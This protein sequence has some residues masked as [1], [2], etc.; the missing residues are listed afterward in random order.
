MDGEGE[1]GAGGGEAKDPGPDT[2]RL[3]DKPSQ[4]E[5]LV[6]ARAREIADRLSLPRPRTDRALHRSGR[7]QRS[8]PYRDGGDELDLDRSIEVLAANPAPAD[9]DLFIR[10]RVR[11]PRSVVLLVDV[12]GSM[13]GERIHT[14]AATVGALSA[15]LDQDRLAVIAFW[16]DAVQL[17]R[18]DQ[19]R[20]PG[21]LVDLMLRIPAQGMTNI[22]YPLELAAAQLSRVQ[23]RE[24]R[25]L[26]LSDCV[27][28]AGADPRPLAARLPRLD[29][30]LDASGVRDIPM[31]HD[32]ARAG[33]GELR[34][35]TQ[36]N[37]VAAALGDIFRS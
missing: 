16:S 1:G 20:R 17:L 3:K 28:V 27:H 5:Q 26:L 7:D 23:G 25:A 21:R 10:E 15:E 14:A 29:V 32:L 31:A 13:R 11:E 6:R 34:M 30:L 2:L 22:G 8:L 35:I 36:H 4:N 18:F 33:R 19:P 24:R 9:E 12:S 37:Q